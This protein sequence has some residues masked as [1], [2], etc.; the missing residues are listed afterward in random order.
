M[1]ALILIN[2]RILINQVECNTLVKFYICILLIL[3]VFS[4]I[5][6][7]LWCKTLKNLIQIKKK[8]ENLQVAI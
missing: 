1:F 5:M 7:A 2:D 8:H 6:I 3:K 4:L